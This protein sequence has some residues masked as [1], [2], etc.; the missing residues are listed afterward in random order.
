[1][2]WSNKK[3][4]WKKHFAIL[5][6]CVEGDWLWLENYWSKFMGIYTAIS[7]EEPEELLDTKDLK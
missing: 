6:I 7:F 5:P 1:M 3:T 2:K 4:T